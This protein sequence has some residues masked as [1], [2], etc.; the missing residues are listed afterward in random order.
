[1]TRRESRVCALKLLFEYSF[2]PEEGPD[3]VLACAAEGR[4]EE[5]PPFAAELF[6][7]AA[8][9]LEEIDR[10]ISAAA[11]NWSLHRIGRVPRAVLRL[12][13]C[14]WR[15]VGTPKEIAANEALE[16][17]RMFDTEESVKFVNGVLGKILTADGVQDGTTGADG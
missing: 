7:T 15:Y 5:I 10:S 9:H 4:E 12:A 13:A 3:E 2:R 11:Q 1:M 14:E 17:T 8:A 16:L 6:R